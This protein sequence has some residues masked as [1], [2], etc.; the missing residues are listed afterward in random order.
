[1]WPTRPGDALSM[2]TAVT[3]L[4]PSSGCPMRLGLPRARRTRFAP[5]AP[6]AP[7]PS[8]VRSVSLVASITASPTEGS[9]DPLRSRH[10]RNRASARNSSD[11]GERPMR[12]TSAPAAFANIA[13]RRPI[14]PGPSTRR[15]R[16]WK[17]EHPTL[18][19]ERCRPGS[20][21]GPERV[22]NR[23]PGERAS[24]DC[25]ANC[26]ASAPGNPPRI[27]TSNRKSQTCW[28]FLKH[29]RQVP[30]PNMVSPVTRRFEP[31]WF[32]PR[33]RTADTVPIHRARVA[34]AY[35]A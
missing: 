6:R 26:S 3:S 21:K 24:G 25:I 27:P 14:V 1:M 12:C 7:V 23:S 13:T 19:E 18:S 10:R 29:R 11:V 35:W 15:D 9:G 2:P 4:R 16:Q 28:L 8:P 34:S 22:V 17:V 30:Q 33:H 20:T 31:R 5:P 32:N